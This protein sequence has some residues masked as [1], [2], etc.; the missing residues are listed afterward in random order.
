MLRFH[1]RTG[2]LNGYRENE[3]YNTAGTAF[4]YRNLA[5]EELEFICVAMPPWPAD[6]EATYLEGIWTQ[7][8]PVVTRCSG[9]H[10]LQVALC[11]LWDPLA[12]FY[13]CVSETYA[14]RFGYCH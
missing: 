13:H 8:L 12:H 2:H 10:S 4:Q 3:D 1:T 6:S 14:L 11:Y 5:N 9:R 7:R